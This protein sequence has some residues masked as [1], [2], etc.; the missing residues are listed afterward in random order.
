MRWI[1]GGAMHLHTENG[2]FYLFKAETQRGTA[3]VL[4][5]GDTHACVEFGEGAKERCMQL[6]IELREKRTRPIGIKP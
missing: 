1:R 4:V 3:Y 2:R 6:A 5:D